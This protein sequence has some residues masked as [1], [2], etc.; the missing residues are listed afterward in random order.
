[1]TAD[2]CCRPAALS[3]A[4]A[5]LSILPIRD[6]GSKA[7]ALDAWAAYQDAPATVE[8]VAGWFA[9]G[10]HGLALVTGRVSGGVEMLELEGRAITEGIGADFRELCRQAG[11]GELLSRIV[12]GCTHRSPGGGSHLIFRTDTPLG[13]QKL[14]RRPATPAELADAPREK[15]K[16]LIETRGEGGY[17]VVP[18]SHGS[19]HPT[20][21]PWEI[22]HGGLAT[23]ATI[24]A[25]E[26][27]AL[28]DI[29]RSLDQM[30]VSAISAPRAR[31]GD[32]DRPGD[33]YN[34]APDA[35]G[36]TEE[37]LL[38]HGWT[39]VHRRAGITYLRRP[40]K[41]RGV[42]ATIGRHPGL[43][44]VFSTSTEFEAPRGYLPFTV[45]AV[46]EHGGDFGAAAASL[47]QDEP[48]ITIRTGTDAP[49]E[50]APAEVEEA[51]PSTWPEPLDNAAYHGVLGE[52]ALAVAPY[53]EAD[54]VGV[55]GTLVSM[56]GAACGGGRALY[57]G[58]LQRSNTSIL[59]VGATGFGGRKG[60]ALDL[61]R[62]VFRL[63][64]PELDALWLVGVASGEA[65]TGHLVRRIEEA[66]AAGGPAED[67]VFLVEPEFGRLLTIL[68][69]EGSTLSAVLRNAWD[70]VPLGHA[71][72]RDESLVTAH[73]VSLLGHIT[74][75][76][77]RVKLTDSDA[78]NGF[79]NRILFLA[80]RRQRL[81]PFPASPDAIVQPFVRR[82]QS[83][84]LE[85]RLPAELAFDDAAR[86]R[87]EDFYAEL[88]VTPRLGL[89][90][91]VTGRHE[92]QVARLALV[93]ALADRSPDVGAVH[94]DAAIAL[95]EYA[96]RSAAWALGDSTG[97]RHADVLLR[98]LDDG[99]VSYDDAKR[100]LG[101]R[102]GADLAEAV[103]VLVDA[104]LATVMKIA[105]ST[106][107]RPRRVIRGNGA[108]GA[109]GARAARTGTKE[110]SA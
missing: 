40:G 46:L 102:T 37:L 30:P 77:L 26:R 38:T 90:G 73:H 89:S 107:G 24:S 82:L 51:E 81:I 15:V 9:N 6:D 32:G 70:G 13:N 75:T 34:E 55:L 86:D 68:N 8:T 33:R 108:N 19:T 50:V 97:N 43:F 58:S 95:A 53:T 67:R 61:A 78:A 66:R 59:L 84:I 3:M 98:M 63:A 69:R 101:L 52:I 16:V 96:R 4:S 62:S 44:Y 109:S 83:A 85:A 28:Y 5:H 36:R 54:P 45:Y 80:V 64:Y 20:G 76:E 103:G 74:P 93:Y 14:A 105:R 110:I 17:F 22:V 47:A 60:T 35:E 1:M 7:P 25:D 39:V 10:R 48:H 56:F 100:A 21:L 72:A 91:A 104:G 88:A 79:A 42:S 41:D 2:T 87:W 23:M 65:I 106:G 92:A 94:L 29:A 57:Q 71:R 49:D 18:P 99:E 12:A 27:D 11:L 31:S